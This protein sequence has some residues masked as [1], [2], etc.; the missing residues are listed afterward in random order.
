MTILPFQRILSR[1]AVFAV[2]LGVF[3]LFSQVIPLNTTDATLLA[4][5]APDECYLALGQNT[6]ND[7][8]PCAPPKRLKINQGYV[9]SMVDTGD[10]IW[11]GTVGNPT[12]TTQGG[13]AQGPT[14]VT[15]YE[16][17]AYAC[18]FDVSPYSPPL[19]APIGDF[20]YPRIFV[21]NK[22]SAV[23]TDV[24][25]KEPPS[26]LNP[27]GI[28]SLVRKT[29]GF[30][31]GT[32]LGNYVVFAGPG[33]IPGLN[34]F[35]FRISDKQFVAKHSNSLFNNVREFLTMGGQTYAGVQRYTLGGSVL[36]MQGPLV[37]GSPLPPRSTVDCRTCFS[38]ELVGQIDNSAANIA[39][40]AGRIYVA[41][42]PDL[43]GNAPLSGIWMSPVVPAGGLT[44]MNAYQWTK[45]WQAD[46]FEPDPILAKGYSGGALRSFDGYLYW[47]TLHLPYSSTIAWVNEYGPPANE[48]EFK[49][50]ILYTFRTATIFRGK[51]FDTGTPTV[52]LLYGARK[53][54]KYTP[55]TPGVWALTDNNLPGNKNPLYGPAGFGQPYNLYTWQMSV[56]DNRLWVGTYD[57]GYIAQLSQEIILPGGRRWPGIAKVAAAPP[58]ENLGA[59]L[60]AFSN[61]TSPAV[62]ENLTG[63]GNYASIG[64]RRL[65]STPDALILGMANPMNLLG[66][67]TDTLPQGGWELIKLTKKVPVPVGK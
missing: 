39:E 15:P 52:D 50:L 26:P 53:L 62:V 56:W 1:T 23:L 34:F 22:T 63:I 44:F 30:R 5:A 13:S 41:T 65:F 46:Q 28:D 27:D 60:V 51:D 19:P 17:S 59:D 31:S 10:D 24:T 49:Q 54:F 64:I 4:K 35:A 36:K 20:R 6:V 12:C 14:A 45:V 25:P 43:S 61:S 37:D 40:H 42:W 11:F 57:W 21:Y 7:K 33:L 2:A 8:P 9:W 3:Q 16:T 32:K 55:G 48:E 38:Y 29:V 47:G 66:D 58:I 67:P 18:E